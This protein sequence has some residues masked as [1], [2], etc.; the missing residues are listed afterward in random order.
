[1]AAALP[2]S[3]LPIFIVGIMLSTAASLSP[4]VLRMKNQEARSKDGHGATRGRPERVQRGY[5][6]HELIAD[7]RRA[8]NSKVPVPAPATAPAS[9]PIMAPAVTSAISAPAP[10]TAVASM[11][12]A[13]AAAA[14][15]GSMIVL[16]T[17]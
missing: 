8:A 1:M 3:L 10:A 16:S 4:P 13:S 2:A 15:L 14:V 17:V 11:R 6:E 9:A 7:S 5:G 12:V